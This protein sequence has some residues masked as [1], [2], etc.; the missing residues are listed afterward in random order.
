MTTDTL[1]ELGSHPDFPET[2][3]LFSPDERTFYF[4]GAAPVRQ[5]TSIGKGRWARFVAPWRD[6]EPVDSEA[7]ATPPGDLRG[8][9]DVMAAVEVDTGIDRDLDVE[10]KVSRLGEAK[11]VVESLIQEIAEL[12]SKQEVAMVVQLFD[13]ALAA[14][15]NVS[16]VEFN[17]PWVMASD[18]WDYEAE[19]ELEAITNQKIS[20]FAMQTKLLKK[21]K[22]LFL[23]QFSQDNAN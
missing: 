3:F 2:E 14:G 19:K 21:G 23:Q 20:A 22:E 12:P 16:I 6:A 5:W 8:L 17:A 13:N 7:T 15:K 4:K 1:V 18:Y 11:R 9:P 10:D